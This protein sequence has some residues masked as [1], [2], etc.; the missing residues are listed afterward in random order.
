MAY[1]P[2]RPATIFDDDNL[3]QFMAGLTNAYALRNGIGGTLDRDDIG[4]C[5]KAISDEEELKSR[6]EP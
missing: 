4:V 5:M 3:T 1:D 6:S 2:K